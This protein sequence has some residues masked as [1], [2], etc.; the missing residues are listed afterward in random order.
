MPKEK[1]LLWQQS[2]GDGFGADHLLFWQRCL[3]SHIEAVPVAELGLGPLGGRSGCRWPRR[4]HPQDCRR[5]A[6]RVDAVQEVQTLTQTLTTRQAVRTTTNELWRVRCGGVG[7]A[8]TLCMAWGAAPHCSYGF[9]V[10]AVHVLECGV[11]LGALR[12]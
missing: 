8:C 2:A 7:G 9:V 4:R 12:E 10:H 6:A 11:S 5:G 1:D 3:F